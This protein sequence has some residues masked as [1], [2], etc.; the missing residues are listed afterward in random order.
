MSTER[1]G[2]RGERG[3][4][5]APKRTLH[6]PQIFPAHAPSALARPELPELEPGKTS[7]VCFPVALPLF[8]LA[9]VVCAHFRYVRK[10]KGIERRGVSTRRRSIYELARCCVVFWPLEGPTLVWTH[11]H[12]GN[13][14]GYGNSFEAR[15]HNH[16]ENHGHQRM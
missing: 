6:F 12:A 16:R 10:A 15:T 4:S 1:S 14:S 5:P 2:S 3:S 11:T 9:F 7:F 13:A 8:P